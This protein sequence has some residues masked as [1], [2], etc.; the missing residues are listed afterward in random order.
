VRA[1]EKVYEIKI[2]EKGQTE[3]KESPG[4][5]KGSEKNAYQQQCNS[6]QLTQ[7]V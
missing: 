5:K 7:T 3:G 1:P 4:K 6:N 2:T